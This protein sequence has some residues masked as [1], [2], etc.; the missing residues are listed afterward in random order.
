MSFLQQ[1]NNGR[2]SGSA[3]IN[4]IGS[5][6]IFLSPTHTGKSNENLYLTDVL[7]KHEFTYNMISI[8]KFVSSYNYRLIFCPTSCTIQDMKT[9]KRNGMI[10][11]MLAYIL[12]M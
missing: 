7:Y 11:L 4:Q 6:I 3:Q 12:L 8:S 9:N 5:K 1:S 2:S 10:I